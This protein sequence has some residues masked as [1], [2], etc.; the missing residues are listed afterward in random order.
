MSDFLAE[1]ADFKIL[2]I[3]EN[4]AATESISPFLLVCAKISDLTSISD[5]IILITHFCDYHTDKLRDFRAN[6]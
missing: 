4:S 2:L 3:N 6:V 5:Q 1:N